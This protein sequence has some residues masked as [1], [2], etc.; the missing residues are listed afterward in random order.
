MFEFTISTINHEDICK[1]IYSTIQKKLADV[2]NIVVCH[3]IGNNCHVTMAVDEKNVLWARSVLFEIVADIISSKYKHEFLTEHI[4]VFADENKRKK[5]I[6]ALVAF[7][8]EE[9]KQIVK[10]S[11]DFFDKINIDSFLNFRLGELYG[12]W[13]SIASIVSENVPSEFVSTFVDDITRQFVGSSKTIVD[14]VEV[15]VEENQIKLKTNDNS[16]N[17]EFGQTD[18]EKTR[19]VCEIIAMSPKKIVLHGANSSCD[20]E[21]MLAGVFGNKIYKTK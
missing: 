7:D 14:L 9:D 8:I 2:A 6:C 12:R 16:C 19:L 1:H 13:K 20:I 17:L 21:N 18:D 3:K 10:N 15:F 11:L 4:K 5:L